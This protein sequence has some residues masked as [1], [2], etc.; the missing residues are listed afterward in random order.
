M[1]KQT[2]DKE[3]I[4]KIFNHPDVYPWISDDSSPSHYTPEMNGYIYLTDETKSGIISIQPWNGITCQ[5]HMASIPEM[6][7][8]GHE[9]VKEALEWGFKNTR[10]S[11]VLGIVP[12]YNE[13]IIKLLEDLNFKQEGRIKD[14]WQKNWKKH[15]QVIYGI[16]KY[17]FRS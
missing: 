17:D 4:E 16:S 9:M 6:W 11:K 8:R 15:D 10:F 2:T 1:V 3:L 5:V 13:F 7:G 14:S 12:D